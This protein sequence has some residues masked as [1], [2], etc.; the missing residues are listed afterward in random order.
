[1]YRI[2]NVRYDK[3]GYSLV[4]VLVSLLIMMIILLGLL[5]SM[6]LYVR[7]NLKNTLKNEAVRIAQECAARLRNGQN[8]TNVVRRFRN[9]QVGFTVSTATAPISSSLENATIT[10]E[11]NYGGTQ[12]SYTLHTVIKR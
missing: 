1:M 2:R 9:F 5:E 12:Y 4:E 3:Q 6:R 8:C 11:Y 7:Y 10:V